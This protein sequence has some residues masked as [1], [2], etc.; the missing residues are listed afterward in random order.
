LQNNGFFLTTNARWSSKSS[1]DADFSLVFIKKN[2]KNCHL[3]L[4]LRT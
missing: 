2:R 1:K 4:G 3:G